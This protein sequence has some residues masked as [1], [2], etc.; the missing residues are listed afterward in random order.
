MCLISAIITFIVG[1]IVPIKKTLYTMAI[2]SVLTP[3]TVQLIYNK[4]GE[5]AYVKLE[6]LLAM[7]SADLKNTNDSK[8]QL[9]GDDISAKSGRA[10]C[11][12][13]AK[14]TSVLLMTALNHLKTYEFE[15]GKK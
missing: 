7:L 11:D 5:T 1:M 2:A 6:D 12:I 3:D 13:L 4:T 14:H 9:T 15:D 8:A 10:A